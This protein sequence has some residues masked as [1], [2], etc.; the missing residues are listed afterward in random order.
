MVN[1]DPPPAVGGA[2][3]EGVLNGFGAGLVPLGGLNMKV[4]PVEPD[5]RFALLLAGETG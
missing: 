5:G 1:N 4:E 2:V 3:E